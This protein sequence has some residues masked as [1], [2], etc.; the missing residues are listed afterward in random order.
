MVCQATRF[1]RPCQSLLVIVCLSS[2]DQP[3]V[4]MLPSRRGLHSTQKLALPLQLSYDGYAEKR[5]H[6]SRKTAPAAD[7]K[8]GG[9]SEGKLSL[10][11]NTWATTKGVWS[12]LGPSTR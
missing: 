9:D 10:R 4:R 12:L 1:L 8:I 11:P 6:F 5:M 3:C 2:L 7:R